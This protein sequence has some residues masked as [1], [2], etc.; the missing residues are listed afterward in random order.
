[1]PVPGAEN[2]PRFSNVA[3]QHE[4]P[5]RNLLEERL[6]NSSHPE[7]VRR[8]AFR[9]IGVLRCVLFLLLGLVPAG[10]PGLAQ[11]TPFAGVLGGVAT[12]SSD[13]R[14]VPTPQG[15]NVALYKPENGP[16]LNVFV[17]AHLK[18]YLS[19]QM[20]YIWNQN[21]L[22]ISSASPTSNSFFEERRRSS[23]KAAIL[24]MLVYFRP[25][26]SR[27]RPYLSVGGGAVQFSSTRE[28]LTA[29]G[30]MP[31]LPQNR[32]SS[33]RP[34]L[35]VAVGM[36]VRLADH[37]ALRYSFSETIRHNDISAQLSPPGRRCLANFQ[38]LFGVI[39]RF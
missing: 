3:A 28:R 25:L 9:G 23:Q 18:Q 17:G 1:M 37:F 8:R 13:A 32:F 30:G 16:A 38:N 36:D 2:L 34:G 5:L 15:L 27:V 29:I 26:D 24:D 11:V 7:L 4:C 39:L 19:V 6:Q 31:A 14:S 20:S 22:T 33:V 21:E 10:T 35:R 12:L